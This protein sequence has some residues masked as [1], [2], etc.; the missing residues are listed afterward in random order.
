MPVGVILCTSMIAQ[1][2]YKNNAWKQV[3]TL[4]Q[5]MM[6]IFSSKLLII[7]F[8]LAQFFVIFTIGVIISAYL[9]PLLN[10]THVFPMGEF[11]WEMFTKHTTAFFVTC[12]PIVAIQ[13]LI[14]LRFNNFMVAVGVGIALVV[15]SIFAINWKYGFIFPYSYSPY[16]FIALSG[17]KRTPDWVNIYWIAAAWFVG[18]TVLNYILYISKKE[19][20]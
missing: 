3:F 6:S 10:G 16:H 17:S 11:P 15:G 14:S 7:L 13:Y 2:E 9:P 8:M 1:L 12:L 20:G 5:T 4:P 19:K 18:V